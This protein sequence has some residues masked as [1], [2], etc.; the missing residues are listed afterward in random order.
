MNCNKRSHVV[1]H[2]LGEMQSSSEL[3]IGSLANHEGFN[4]VRLVL[5]AI[6]TKRGSSCFFN[7][8]L[9]TCEQFTPA[10]SHRLDTHVN[11]VLL[12]VSDSRFARQSLD[13]DLRATNPALHQVH[14][15]C[16]PLR[17]TRAPEHCC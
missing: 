4:Q 3:E 9:C 17:D 10:T 7:L 1:Q 14:E 5:L 15:F 12:P 13:D 6:E 8:V 2:L 11:V 16:P